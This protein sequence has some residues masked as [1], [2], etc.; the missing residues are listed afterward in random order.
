MENSTMSMKGDLGAEL[1]RAPQP[2]KLHRLRTPMGSVILTRDRGQASIAGKDM[3]STNFQAVHR[4]NGRILDVQ[5][6]GSGL[7]TNIGVNLMANDFGWTTATLK[8]MNFHAVGSGSTA[9]AASDFFLQTAIGAGS[10]TGSTNGYMTG[11]QTNPLQGQYRTTS[12]FTA[13]STITINEWVLAMSNASPFTGRSATSTTSNSLTD[14]GASFTTAGSGLAQWSVEANSTAI[15]T[16]TSTVMGQVASN[17]STALTLL[18]GWLT[19]ANAAASTPSGT[20]NYVVYPSI[21][22]HKIVGPFTLN[23]GD[24]LQL[25]YTLTINAGG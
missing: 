15:N 22:D 25:T 21:W 10:L 8:A 1:V 9:A 3:F 24:Q 23:S 2:H 4:R 16:P 14:T 18:N 6:L 17:T 11:T 7:V 12:T 19:L 20:T 5:D 13:A